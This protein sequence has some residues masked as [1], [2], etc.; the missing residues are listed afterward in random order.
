MDI[1]KGQASMMRKSI[2]RTI[3]ALI[4][5]LIL[6]ACLGQARMPEMETDRAAT[7]EPPKVDPTIASAQRLSLTIAGEQLTSSQSIPQ[8]NHDLIG[9]SDCL[10]CHKQGVSG[11]P[12]IPDAHR[13]LESNVCQTC[14]V[15]PASA[16]LSGPELY[17]RLCARC[18]GESG[19]GRFGP[20]INLKPYLSQVSDT[21]LRE[22][23]LRGRGA[24]E[25][26]SWGELGLLTD[27]QIDDLVSMI[28]SWES[29]AP[30]T[31]TSSPFDTIS[32]SLGDPE[33][34]ETLFAQFCS[35][36]HGLSGETAVG[37]GFILFD[38]VGL[39]DD[40]VLSR[41]IRGG[42]E[43]M[44][45]FHSLLTTE[46]INN[47]LALMRLWHAGPSSMATPIALSGEEV[48]A[49]VC[50]RC[51]GSNGEGGVGGPLNSKEFLS[52]N[53]DDAIR[54]WIF[55]GTLGTSM[56]SW[57]DLSLLS[58][59]QIDELVDF[60]RAWEPSAPSTT[61]VES[62]SIPAD[63]A[64]GDASH[65]EQLFAQFCSGCHGLHGE[66]PTASIILNSEEFLDSVN[67]EIL[68]SQIQNG[69]IAMP[70]FHAILTSR[71]VN[72][73][74]AFMRSGFSS[75]SVVTN[76]PSFVDDVMPIFA[77]KCSA[78]H[79]SAGGWDSTNF[80]AVMTTGAHAPNVIPGD[81]DNSP[82]A[83]RILGTQ[84]EGGLMPPAGMMPDGK[85]EIILNWILA[86][87]LD[88]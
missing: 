8:I 75:E 23:L 2:R 43:E 44:P 40:E 50:A 39:I 77:E 6:S 59:E 48:F 69:G 7:I 84:S 71:E 81:A 4:F 11:A 72:D 57:G 5:F 17:L 41:Q 85:I 10:M 30:E 67:D 78:C 68:A 33:E 65:G 42:S 51:H 70:S 49:R 54:Q 87:A 9:R 26:L 38:V 79:G 45:P 24:S 53:D 31:S 60:I 29:T 82:L 21:E 86:G 22:A 55:R 25:M 15:A 64:L 56:L 52:A 27:G 36:C 88:N 16:E 35:G 13:G 73:L 34:G 14:H 83:R 18:H 19:E 46:D 74:L 47:L 62:T 37:E 63:S 76:S 61:D 80:E 3:F 1:P 58:S 32:A 12:R 66:R 28:R 20:A